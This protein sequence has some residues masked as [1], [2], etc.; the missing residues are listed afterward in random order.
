MNHVIRC[1]LII[2]ILSQ[3]AQ[4]YPANIYGCKGDDVV[5]TYLANNY[6]GRSTTSLTKGSLSMTLV[7]SDFSVVEGDE[8]NFEVKGRGI[9]FDCEKGIDSKAEF[10]IMLKKVGFKA[11]TKADGFE[12]YLKIRENKGGVNHLIPVTCMA[13]RVLYS[14]DSCIL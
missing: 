4:A 5:L 11:F 13:T 9:L 10:S 8:H 7:G 14:N 1:C 6:Q 2:C 3:T 12:T